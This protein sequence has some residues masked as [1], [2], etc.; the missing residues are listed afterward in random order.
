MSSFK[1]KLPLFQANDIQI[2]NDV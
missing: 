1:E 2:F